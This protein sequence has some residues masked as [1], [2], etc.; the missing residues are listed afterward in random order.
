[1][2]IP[3]YEF[4]EVM[5][6]RAVDKDRYRSLSDLR[7]HRVATLGATLPYEATAASYAWPW[8]VAA[9]ASAGGLIAASTLLPDHQS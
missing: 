5:T 9:L 7:G 1:M 4:R 3:Y 6:I 2:T 8:L